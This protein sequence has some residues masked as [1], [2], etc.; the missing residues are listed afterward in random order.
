MTLV[1]YFNEMYE[2][3]NKDW[4]VDSALKYFGTGKGNEGSEEAKA[5]KRFYVEPND[6]RFR[7][8]FLNFNNQRNID[9]VVWFLNNN[10]GEALTLGQLKELFGIYHAKC[11]L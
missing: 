1:E 8:I 10:K 11:N 6:K 4:N 2:T 5:I 9:S 7:Q 3:V